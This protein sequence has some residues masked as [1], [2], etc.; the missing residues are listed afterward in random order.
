MQDKTP[1]IPA[2]TILLLKHVF[3]DWAYKV[4]GGWVT[5]E[6]QPQPLNPQFVT[7]DTEWVG[8]WCPSW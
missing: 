5:Q 3:Y 1:H 8:G 6:G 4:F 7:G 2:C